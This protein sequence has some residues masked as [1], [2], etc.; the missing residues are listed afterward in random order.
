[1][2]SLSQAAA[3]VV[4]SLFSLYCLVLMLRAIMYYFRFDFY[5]PIVQAITKLT[6]PVV[7]PLQQFLPKKPIDFGTLAALLIIDMLKFFIY[8]M[9][10]GAIANPVGLL[11][12]SLG[13]LFNLFVNIFF[14]AIIIRVILSFVAPHTHNPLTGLLYQLTEPLFRPIQRLIPPVGGLDLSPIFLL[15]FLQVVMM[16]IGNNL[17]SLGRGLL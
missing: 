3:F 16:L 17:M 15:I 7:R 5:H 9:I 10:F 4:Q 12:L 11:I 14:F 6:D 2:S 8:F 1:M 13:D